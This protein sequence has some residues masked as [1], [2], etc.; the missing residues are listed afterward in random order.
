MTADTLGGGGV[1]DFSVLSTRAQRQRDRRVTLT[2]VVMEARAN[3]TSDNTAAFDVS[4]KR[5]SQD[6]AAITVTFAPISH[7]ILIIII[8]INIIV[9][10]HRQSYRG[11]CIYLP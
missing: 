5:S 9:K 4:A 2:T 3:L 6:F 10:R 8:I 1:H 11:A 7:T